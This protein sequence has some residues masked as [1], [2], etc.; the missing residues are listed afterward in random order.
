MR[1]EYDFSQAK[2]ANQVPHLMALQSQEEEIKLDED[3]LAQFRET[4][5]GWQT[6]LNNALKEWLSEHSNQLK[7]HELAI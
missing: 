5:K 7:K 1:K 3:V 6:R 4:G 2:R